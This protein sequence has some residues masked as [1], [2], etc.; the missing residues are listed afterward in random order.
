MKCKYD[1]NEECDIFTD[2]IDCWYRNR[3]E[4]R[5]YKLKR[6]EKVKS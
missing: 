6:E 4:C 2:T 5:F 1:K 3:G